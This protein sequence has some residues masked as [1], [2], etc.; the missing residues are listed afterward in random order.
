MNSASLSPDDEP[1]R[2]EILRYF[3]PGDGVELKPKTTI[4]VALCTYNG[5]RHLPEQLRSIAAQDR[6]PDEVVI[7]DDRSTD[8][9]PAI[10]EQFAAHAPF[11]VRLVV[12]G[13]NLGPTKNFERAIGMCAGDI[14]VL[15]DQD[16]SW[17]GDWLQV[18]EDALAQRPDAGALFADADLVDENLNPLGYR[19]WD[20]AYFNC[21][22]RRQFDAGNAFEALLAHN[23]VT[24]ATMAFRSRYRR[25][26]LPIPSLWIHDGWIAI[27]IAAVANMIC[28]NHPLIQYRQ[29]A[30]QQ[31]D[32]AMRT[33]AAHFANTRAD[34]NQEKYRAMPEQYRLVYE[35]LKASLGAGLAPGID[36][37]LQQ[38]IRH[39]DRRAGLARAR[40][41]RVPAIAGELALNRYA[42]FGY[43]WKGALR[44]LLVNLEK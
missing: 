32:A 6:L 43:G 2:L 17:F 34:D 31:L 28:A 19:L 44:D 20:S 33:L 42:R 5:E 36:H 27:L 12:N 25:L 15:S 11:P 7:S 30:A 10:A 23:V 14:I 1:G 35:R 39:M 4:S 9:T 21:K 37:L 26:V 3:L 40:S 16:D 18:T 22:L 24:G 41:W 8:R 13:R 29:H 38:K